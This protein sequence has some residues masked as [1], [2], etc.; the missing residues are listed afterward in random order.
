VSVGFI[1]EVLHAEWLAN[2]VLVLKRIKLIGACA[3]MLVTYSQMLLIKNKATQLLK[4]KD[5]RPLKHYLL[6]NNDLR[7]KVMKDTPS[8]FMRIIVHRDDICYS[9]IHS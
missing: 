2:L 9:F 3:L 8:S 5:L 4:I 6:S 1:R 7:T